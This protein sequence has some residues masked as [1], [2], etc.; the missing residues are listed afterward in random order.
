MRQHSGGDCVYQPACHAYLTDNRQ[1]LS[2]N[3]EF[4]FSNFEIFAIPYQIIFL[5]PTIDRLGGRV[6]S[7]EETDS[8]NVKPR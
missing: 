2:P 1:E 3:D 7:H 4:E 8:Q 5:G 6:E